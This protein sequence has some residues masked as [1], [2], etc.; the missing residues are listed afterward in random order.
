MIPIK[1][2]CECGQRYAFEIEPVGGRVPSTITCPACGADGTAAANAI[3]AQ[4]GTA[5]P[6]T[7]ATT[8]APLR[9]ALPTQPV[10][11]AS[12]PASTRPAPRRTA[13]LSRQV[14]RTQA[15]HEARARISWG[16]SPKDVTVYLMTQG[17]S[18]EEASDFVE[19]LFQER[20]ATVRGNGIKKIIGGVLL[21]CLPI[22]TFVAFLISGTIYPYILAGT[23]IGGF[24][25]VWIIFKGI[26][27]VTN[28]K[29]E[30][31]D[32]AEQ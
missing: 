24:Y 15:E 4:S 14:D 7:G 6:T 10:Q 27:M 8:S 2:Q 22:G 31:G 23:I 21:I 1:I 29:S 30:G 9:V 28:P 5:Q 19:E 25:G 17:F 13:P 3:L 12:T 26:S 18:R 16:D 32:V 20:A 11:S